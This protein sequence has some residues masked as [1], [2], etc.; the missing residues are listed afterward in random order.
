MENTLWIVAA[1]VVI[2]IAVAVVFGRRLGWVK[3]GFFGAG[4]EA[5][6]NRDGAIADDAI[7]GRHVI[8]ET[9]SGGDASAKRAWAK[10]GDV[11]VTS[12][13]QRPK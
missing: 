5:R 4:V 10:K 1:I 7:A 9:P 8:A 12:G 3:V 13:T 6:E 11:R 2:V